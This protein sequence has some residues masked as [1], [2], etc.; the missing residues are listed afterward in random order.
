MRTS[1]LASVSSSVENSAAVFSTGLRAASEPREVHSPWTPISQGSGVAAD[2]LYGSRAEA[3]GERLS[4]VRGISGE[5][6]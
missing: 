3:H 4:G 6:G 1:R 2:A 5:A